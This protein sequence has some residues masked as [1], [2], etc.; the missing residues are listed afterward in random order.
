[1]WCLRLHGEEEYTSCEFNATRREPHCEPR[2]VSARVL[3]HSSWK[4]QK[5]L[6]I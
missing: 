4:A 3:S 6:G 1:M 5:S 2:G